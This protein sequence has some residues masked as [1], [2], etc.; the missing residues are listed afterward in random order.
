MNHHRI[1]VIKATTVF[2]LMSTWFLYH[3]L[4]KH[5]FLNDYTREIS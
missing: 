4:K 5:I 1:E 2:I 3:K